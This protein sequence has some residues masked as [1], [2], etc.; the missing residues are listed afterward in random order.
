MQTDFTSSRSDYLDGL[1]ARGVCP[2]LKRIEALGPDQP[3]SVSC[4]DKGTGL[5]CPPW[6]N[7]PLMTLMP[8]IKTYSG[9]SAHYPSIHDHPA[10][11]RG[12]T[13][14][15]QCYQWGRNRTRGFCDRRPSFTI[16]CLSSDDFFYK[17]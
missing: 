1:P 8:L 6:Q 16:R 17:G 14:L 7:P 4:E 2:G 3:R 11:I 12:K 9:H 5:G 13:P 10:K 15:D